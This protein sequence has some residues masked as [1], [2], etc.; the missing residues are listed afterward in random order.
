VDS[1]RNKLLNKL[2]KM[3]VG[4]DMKSPIARLKY[5]AVALI[6]LICLMRLT[7]YLILSS[8]F[9]SR[10]EVHFQVQDTSK[11]G[12]YAHHASFAHSS[13]LTSFLHI[14]LHLLFL[15]LSLLLLRPATDRG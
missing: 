3:L 12:Q 14:L 5:G 4:P 6:L 7:C 2:S 11:V 13:P 9:T 15:I 1:R 10:Y 8:L